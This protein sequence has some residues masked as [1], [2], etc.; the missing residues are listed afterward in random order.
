VTQLG[1]FEI[2][3][4]LG[5]GGCGVVFLA[6]DPELRREVALK[7]PRPEVL[8]TSELRERFRREARA[9]AGL[10][11]PNLVPVYEAGEVGAVC[12]I[13]S[14]YCP[15]ITLA[16][17]LRQQSEPLSFHEAAT[18]VA[19]LADAVDHA[20]TRGVLHRDLKPS[21]VLLQIA[22][23]RLQ[24]ENQQT[25][26]SGQSAI[27]SLQ[28]VIPKIS[29]FG[30]AKLV[31]GDTGHETRTGALLGTPAYMA[32]EQ[33]EGK[34]RAIGPA[35]DVYALGTILYEL[36]TG[37]LPFRG[38]SDLDTLEQVRSQEPMAPSRLRAR[39]PQDLTTIC[40]KCL[41]KDPHRR[42]ASA[43]DLAT[44]LQ[45]FLR[46]EPIRAR[47]AGVWEHGIKWARRRPA[48]AA[49]LAVSAIA[50]TAL[51][52][53]TA[54]H[55]IRLR[56]AL[57]ETGKAKDS[58]EFNLYVARINMA[59]RAWEE[60]QLG[61]MQ[62][63][64]EGLRPPATGT[65]EAPGFE[66]RY[67]WRLCHSDRL[68]L[69]GHDQ[70]VLCVAYSPDGKYLA[71]GGFDQT[72]RVCDATTGQ[73]VRTFP[74]NGRCYR[75]AFSPDGLCLA[76]AGA[77]KVTVWEMATGRELFSAR[78]EVEV[79]FSHDGRR[80]AFSSGSDEGRPRDVKVCELATGKEVLSLK[81][82]AGQV[83]ALA[84]SPNGRDLVAGSFDGRIQVWEAASGKG[85]YTLT[86]GTGPVH[87]LAF[88][89]DSQRLAAAS[90]EGLVKVWEAATGKQVLSLPGHASTV[91]S[92]AFSPD[93]RFL[94]SAGY[95]GIVKV[96]EAATGRE[97]FNLK[98]QTCIAFSPD[99]QWLASA[100]AD[101]VKVWQV[102][103]QEALTL[104]G[105]K[106]FIST[107]AFSPDGRLL[108]SA[109]SDH[110]VRVWDAATSQ[111]LRTLRG[112]S[113][114]VW[115]VA[116]SPDGRYLAS[117]SRDRTVKLWDWAT[118]QV[119]R[120]LSGHTDGVLGVAF[121]PDGRYLVSTSRDWTAK[122]WETATGKEVC[123]YTG[124]LNH[125]TSVAFSPDG[126]YLATASVDRRVKIWNAATGEAILTF[127]GHG[128]EVWGVAFHPDGMRI[129]SGGDD[130]RVKVWERATGRELL[131]FQ[132][133]TPAV[134]G[135]AFTPDGSRLASA[136]DDGTVKI[137]ETATGQIL[138]SLKGHTAG[139]LTVAFSPDGLRLASAGT[140]R[141]IRIWEGAAPTKEVILQRQ[142]VRLVQSLFARLVHKPDVLEYLRNAAGLE[143]ALRTE[144]LAQAER[145][146]QEECNDLLP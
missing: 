114:W 39:L 89:P 103:S 1:R 111:Q 66:W 63:L 13:A 96:W 65:T 79:A 73:V 25:P 64:L 102:A 42:Y 2:E 92:V 36:L 99:G 105:H 62:Y 91:A 12:Y 130:G 129:A 71:S 21:N 131:T 69:P 135:V 16:Q 37:R 46:G 126:A 41:E 11:H 47:R 84:F 112:H 88:S 5:R 43:A 95:D 116:F 14:A 40:L 75:V 113:A 144:A 4:E 58:A 55:N 94:A 123:K 60:G 82:P 76:S 85:R 141:T 133:G 118:G 143:A 35:T 125:V 74:T 7:V 34:I 136:G 10:D 48:W 38:E 18:L 145:Y 8:A 87:S 3:R 33:A 70:L 22:D 110:T 104:K 119:V 23:W 98:G 61:R 140:D 32:P 81:P 122:R 9:A 115:G 49:L 56:G 26:A 19:T 20:H 17:W 93:G 67:L 77:V 127:E 52:A 27:L 30:L 128:D 54:W 108:A 120:T 29:D 139:L 59:Q 97:A 72:V 106:E 45:R 80:L 142:A 51:L 124:H 132:G 6:Y 68:T 107:V 53:G 100:G 90:P 44:D 109:S 50:L 15:G 57:T 137:W 28:S 24:T 134:N 83:I 138:L 86:A 78:S 121:S 117:T 101:G 146:A 31:E